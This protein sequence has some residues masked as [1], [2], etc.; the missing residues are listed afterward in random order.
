M[1]EDYYCCTH[2]HRAA[3]LNYTCCCVFISHVGVYNWISIRSLARASPGR[4]RET[5]MCILYR[6]L[7]HPFIFFLKFLFDF[8]SCCQ[9]KLTTHTS[10]SGE[11]HSASSKNLESEKEFA[12]GFLVSWELYT[13]GQLKPLRNEK[14]KRNWIY[15]NIYDTRLLVWPAPMWIECI[16]HRVKKTSW[17]DS[18]ILS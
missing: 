14:P 2:A 18:F 15:R 5:F 11:T 17:D 3:L 9:L 16:E 1:L 7:K 4:S 8:P 12:A 13:E 10:E 6:L